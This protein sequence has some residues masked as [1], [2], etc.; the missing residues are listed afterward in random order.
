VHRP[1]SDSPQPPL[2]QDCFGGDEISLRSLRA[3][4]NVLQCV[5]LCQSVLQCVAVC[6]NMVQCV[7]VCCSKVP[8][9]ALATRLF[10]RA[11]QPASTVIARD[12]VRVAVCCSVWQC[13]EVR[14]NALQCI[15]VWYSALQGVAVKY[16]QPPLRHGCFGGE[17]ISLR[18]HGPEL[19]FERPV[20]YL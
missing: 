12:F 9:A 14:C 13:V 17:G 19:L 7:A 5:V 10:W 3:C 1:R 16:L 20:F 4:C 6:C 15:A 11:M 18:S 2:R 8:S